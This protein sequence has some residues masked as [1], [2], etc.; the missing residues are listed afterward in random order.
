MQDVMR[1]FLA[2]ILIYKNLKYIRSHTGIREL[3]SND[4]PETS[5]YFYMPYIASEITNADNLRELTIRYLF[6]SESNYMNKE[7]PVYSYNNFIKKYKI[8]KIKNEN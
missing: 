5:R 2:H 3:E 7:A 6:L 8:K 4:N 1:V